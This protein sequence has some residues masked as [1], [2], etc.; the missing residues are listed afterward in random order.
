MH[1]TGRSGCRICLSFKSFFT[2]PGGHSSFSSW[3][4]C[5]NSLSGSHAV[6][7][8]EEYY[9]T[10]SSFGLM[11]TGFEGHASSGFS[12][13][14]ES[15]YNEETEFVCNSIC[16]CVRL[17]NGMCVSRDRRTSNQIVLT[18]NA[19]L[20]KSFSGKQQQQVGENRSMGVHENP[21]TQTVCNTHNQGN[22]AVPFQLTH[23]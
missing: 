11:S 9:I 2:Q 4:R 10:L 1:C 18:G 6:G 14:S 5:I 19:Q 17:G 13:L 15:H 20:L 8:C 16:D 23:L 22:T 12:R 7:R 21:H 3:I